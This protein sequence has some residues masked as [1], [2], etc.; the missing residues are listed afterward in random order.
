MPLE[1]IS[2]VGAKGRGRWMSD[3]RQWIDVKFIIQTAISVSLAVG[4]AVLGSYIGTQTRTAVL[5]S[6]VSSLKETVTSQANATRSALADLS[7]LVTST[8]KETS[9]AVA[10]LQASV[11]AKDREIAELR[12]VN[13]S[14]RAEMNDRDDKLGNEIKLQELRVDGMGKSIARIEGEMNADRANRP[15]R[16][17]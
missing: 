8:N 12:R 6:V 11:A 16:S 7:M 14:L 5:E 10:D 1:H 4:G 9:R 17:E 13:D 15:K 3:R 2:G